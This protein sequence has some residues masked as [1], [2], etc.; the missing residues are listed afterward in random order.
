VRY[1]FIF[2]KKRTVGLKKSYLKNVKLP[3]VL[4]ADD[5]LA[6]N[7]SFV[8]VFE[9]QVAYATVS[10][11]ED[12]QSL[13]SFLAHCGWK[14]LPSLIVLSYRL[15]D[16]EA[17]D[18]LRELLLDTRYMKIPKMVWSS[19]GAQ[20]ELE[21]CRILGVKHFFRTPNDIFELENSIRKIDELLR[22]ELT[23]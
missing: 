18:L 2:Q 22:A 8:T 9:K 15:R 21:E 5:D 14:D 13:L 12:G 1:L 11:V 3:Y 7:N 10:T 19:T 16:M 17:P 23:L 4:L 6:H 20:K